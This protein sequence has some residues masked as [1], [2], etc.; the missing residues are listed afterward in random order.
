MAY[1]PKKAHRILDA[2]DVINAS[3]KDIQILRDTVDAPY[4][5][6]RNVNIAIDSIASKQFE[7]EDINTIRAALPEM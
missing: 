1:D 5:Q 6:L 7:K 4:E 3:T 2:V